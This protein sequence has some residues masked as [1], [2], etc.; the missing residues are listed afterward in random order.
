MAETGNIEKLAKIV[1]KDIFKWFKW[2]QYPLADTNWKCE[3]DYHGKKTHPSDVVFYYTEPYSGKTV[4]INTDLKS[5]AKKSITKASVEVAL[6]NLALSI[7]CA[8]VSEDWQDTYVTDQLNFG[9]VIGLLFIYNHDGEFDKDIVQVTSALDFKNISIPDSVKLILMDSLLIERLCN[10]VQDM[11]SLTAD[12]I[13]PKKDYTFFYPDLIRK[14]RKGDE[15]NQPASVEALTSPWLIIKHK[16]AEE[17]SDGFIIYYHGEGST[18]EEFIYLLDA[19]SH[20]Q[21]LLSNK[22]IRIR[23][24][25]GSDKATNNFEKAKLEYLAMWGL[26]DSR[27]AQLNRIEAN[28][29]TH[30]T[31][32]FST[33]EIGME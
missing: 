6:K 22:A 29:I 21:M 9:E 14:R 28:H 2:S 26:D 1:S 3:I 7:E 25:S 12:D 8:N 18:T 5:Y 31:K 24:T 11:K 27:E 32:K 10:I 19:L 15:W 16:S 13:L 33:I 23:L 30:I 20:Y 17:S 4:Y